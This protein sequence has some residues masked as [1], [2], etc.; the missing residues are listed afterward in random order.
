MS[1]LNQF[2]IQVNCVPL[3]VRQDQAHDLDHLAALSSATRESSGFIQR[4]VCKSISFVIFYYWLSVKT[5]VFWIYWVKSNI[6]INFPCCF[7]HFFTWLP[8]RWNCTRGYRCFPVGQHR[9]CSFSQRRRKGPVLALLA[10]RLPSGSWPWVGKKER[11][12]ACML[13]SAPQSL[14]ILKTQWENSACSSCTSVIPFL[15]TQLNS[16]I[17]SQLLFFLSMK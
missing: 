7:L 9:P 13:R 3:L 12:G 1:V 11:A 5:I 14:K 8:E 4:K 6:K 2:L 16:I 10:P 15:L 17:S